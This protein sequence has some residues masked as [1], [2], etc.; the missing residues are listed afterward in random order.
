MPFEYIYLDTGTHTAS[1]NIITQ[2][3]GHG[4]SISWPQ[5]SW[6]EFVTDDFSRTVAFAFTSIFM[7][8]M[9]WCRLSQ[10]LCTSWWILLDMLPPEAPWTES[11]SFGVYEPECAKP[12]LTPPNQIDFQ[13]WAC[14]SFLPRPFLVPSLSE[15]IRKTLNLG[16]HLCLIFSQISA[17]PSLLTM[18]QQWAY[19]L[20]ADVMIPLSNRLCTGLLLP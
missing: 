17:F 1:N 12:R 18:Y 16:V 14:W 3:K 7:I 11:L 9:L 6:T 10:A 8:E 15:M 2:I 13:V 19:T 20:H 4:K 5:G